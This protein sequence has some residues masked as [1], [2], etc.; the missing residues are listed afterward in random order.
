MTTLRER[1]TVLVHT[2]DREIYKNNLKYVKTKE[3]KRVSSINLRQFARAA[4]YINELRL[5]CI[6]ATKND[7][8]AKFIKDII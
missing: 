6:N 5:K 2:Q 7:V 3:N 8:K 4:Q 1:N